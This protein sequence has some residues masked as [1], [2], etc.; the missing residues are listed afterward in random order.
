MLFK[1][2]YITILNFKIKNFRKIL[3]YLKNKFFFQ[4]INIQYLIYFL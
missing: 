4:I 2:F 3:I 1:K